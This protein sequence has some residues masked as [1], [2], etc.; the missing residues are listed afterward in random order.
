MNRLIR[1]K[2]EKPVSEA[3]ATPIQVAV[4]SQDVAQFIDQEVIEER[5]DSQWARVK[6]ELKDGRIVEGVQL[7]NKSDEEP[8]DAEI[9]ID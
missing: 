7:T 1:D 9:L 3:D 8:T 4:S 5:G 2:M 6:C